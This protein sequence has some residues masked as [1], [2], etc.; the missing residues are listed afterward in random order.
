M[1]DAD[2]RRLATHHNEQAEFANAQRVAF[3][4]GEVYS[5]G[6]GH[7]TDHDEWIKE[8]IIHFARIEREH[9]A[10]RDA[11]LLHCPIFCTAG[12]QCSAASRN[13]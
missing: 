8:T 4:K 6:A 5:L 12:Y 1:T 7:A 10:I 9:I 13:D 3:Q 11:F 2:L